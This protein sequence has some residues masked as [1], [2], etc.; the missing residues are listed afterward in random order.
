[1]IK[2]KIVFVFAETGHINTS[3]QPALAKQGASHRH[4]CLISP[5]L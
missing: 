1:M 5:V 2:R 3:I 4:K